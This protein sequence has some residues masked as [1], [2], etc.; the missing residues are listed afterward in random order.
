MLKTM[1]EWVV[2]VGV[3]LAWGIA[4]A[5]TV[6]ALTMLQAS[7]SKEIDGPPSISTPV[8]PPAAEARLR[9]GPPRPG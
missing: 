5:Y 9:E 6:H 7:L 4:A 3:L 8:K 2:P 1:R